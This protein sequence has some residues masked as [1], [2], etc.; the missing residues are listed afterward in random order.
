MN[1]KSF[2][3]GLL[4]LFS[5]ATAWA[6]DQTT[7]TLLGMDVS[8]PTL[9]CFSALPTSDDKFSR[10]IVTL[11]KEN[12]LDEHVTTDS[13]PD[14]VEAWGSVCVVDLSDISKPRV[15]GW[16]MENFVYPA[17]TYKMYVMGE[18][19]RQACVGERS[20]DDMTTVVGLNVRDDDRLSTGD[21]VSLAEVLRLMCTYSDNTAANVAIDTVD[22]RKA[23]ALLHAMGCF[24]SEVTRKYLPRSREPEEYRKI[25]STV[26]SALH[27]ATFLWATETGAIGGGRGRGLIKGFLGTNVQ[28]KTRFRAGLPESATIYSKTGEWN[29]FTTEA[30]IVE[31]GPVKYIMVVMTVQPISVAAP[32]MAA[33]A[34]GV[35]ELLS[36]RR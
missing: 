24:G 36:A 13:N 32:R 30:A 9:S 21:V 3:I 10:Q 22:R 15:G 8:T 26:S 16:E 23:S 2:C 34:R 17:S 5:F 12:H 33:F 28:N 29:T 6:G 7:P 4:M 20:L 27:F 14:N 18:A 1:L 35:H 25:R 11:V 19:V 31:D